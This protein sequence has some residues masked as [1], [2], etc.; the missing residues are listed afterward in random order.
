MIS[1]SRVENVRRQL[2]IGR[3]RAELVLERLE[4][5]LHLAG[6]ARKDVHVLH[7]EPGRAAALDLERPCA[8]GQQRPARRVLGRTSE[9][10]AEPRGDLRVLALRQVERRRDRLARDVVRRPAEPARHH[11]DVGLAPLRAGR[12]ARSRPPRRAPRRR[13]ARRSRA[14][15]SRA[16]EPRRVRVLD[17]SRDDLAPDGHNGGSRMPAHVPSMDDLLA[18]RAYECRLTPDRALETLEDAEGFLQDRGLLTRTA[19]SRA[20]EPVRRVPRGAVR[21]R[22]AGVRAVAADEVPVVRAARRARLSRPRD[23]S[24]QEPARHRRDGTADRP[25]RPRRA[26]AAWRRKTPRG[27]RL[28]RHL[29]DAGPSEL[30]DLQL[31]L[32]LKPKELKL[33][34]SPLERCAAIVSRSIVYEEPH[35]H[36]SVLSRWDQLYP[37]PAEGGGLARAGRRRRAS[38]RRRAGPR[39]AALVLVAVVLGRLDPGRRAPRPGG[40]AR[41]LSGNG[42]RASAGSTWAVTQTGVTAYRAE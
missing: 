30:E 33:L 13:G 21:A 40:R 1:L 34:R 18:R 39:G 11:H 5:R 38:R 7:H 23:P 32:E 29:A 12:A 28:L 19:D 17:V 22:Q 42:F 25:D 37:E 35:R 3:S 10:R 20:A 27:A 31:E 24:R 4:H 36:T 8:F 26:R 14:R 16:R 15:S 6:Q 9:T 2:A 41:H